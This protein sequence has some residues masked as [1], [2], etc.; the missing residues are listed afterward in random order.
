MTDSSYVKTIVKPLLLVLMSAM[1]KWRSYNYVQ[2]LRMH[3]TNSV[4][5]SESWRSD[6][7]VIQHEGISLKKNSY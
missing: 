1:I 2:T 5:K 3:S 4:I 6:G 7:Y